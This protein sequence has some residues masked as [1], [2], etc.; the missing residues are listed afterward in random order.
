M[1]AQAVPSMNL[2]NA[3]VYAASKLS[4]LNEVP[5]NSNLR[6]AA[7]D[8]SLHLYDQTI[9]DNSTLGS[10]FEI[11]GP[12]QTNIQG[13]NRT[14]N[15]VFQ[16]N[17]PNW[18]YN[19]EVFLEL[20]VRISCT[21]NA[22][23]IAT[24]ATINSKG[25]NDP[26]LIANPLAC[27][28]MNSE[29]TSD[30]PVDPIQLL[31]YNILK[32]SYTPTESFEMGFFP[33]QGVIQLID[34]FEVYGGTNNQPLGRTTMFQQPNLSMIA[35]DER[36]NDLTASISGFSGLPISNV[37][38]FNS[39]SP[40]IDQQTLPQ[41]IGPDSFVYSTGG[42][43]ASRINH[44]SLQSFETTV[45]MCSAAAGATVDTT[46]QN[47]GS[48]TFNNS[49]VIAIPLSKISEWFKLNVAVPP[50]FRYKLTLNFLNSPITIYSGNLKDSIAA[51]G[52]RH[53]KI[54]LRVNPNASPV[55]KFRT[56]ILNPTVQQMLN[57][58]WS[59]NMFTYNL[60]TCE[61]YQIPASSFPYQQIIQTSQQR[62]L[63]LRICCFATRLKDTTNSLDN[64]FYQPNTLVPI[65][66]AN[67]NYMN[68][69]E[70]IISISGRDIIRYTNDNLNQAG[71]VPSAFEQIIN[72][73]NSQSG[74]N[75]AISPSSTQL[76]YWG[77]FS[78]QAFG[79]PIDIN[80]T[81]NMLWDNNYYATDQGA[82]QIKVTI[83]TPAAIHPDFQWVILKKYTEQ[84]SIDPNNKVS[85]T[86]WPARVVQS[87]G[88]SALSQP[89]VIMGN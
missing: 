20:P 84:E 37:K 23:T 77:T 34:S 89:N 86:A 88:T 2:G 60:E 33:N 17:N 67:Y 46:D 7:G 43:V 55:L 11:V 19:G 50:E 39:T 71:L 61:S 73:K 69:Q 15:Y 36:L 42:P 3:N 41:Y 66:D 18:V 85:I 21:M 28:A 16:Y 64:V 12:T 63:S 53:A 13:T 6:F 58:K 54:S 4:N 62:P 87:Q 47:N 29:Y 14:S 82:V 8:E 22:L 35:S 59:A 32:S 26:I 38:K 52:V 51:T 27:M 24:A 72:L 30:P 25:Y 56:F 45:R 57:T 10:T 5:N 40:F 81:P 49:F 48:V 1:S 9:L 68:I 79:A 74:Q 80:I 76:G 31:N 44:H 78:S 83:K 70:I 65:L 75:Y